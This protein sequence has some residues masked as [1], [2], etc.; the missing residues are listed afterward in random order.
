MRNKHFKVRHNTKLGSY[1]DNCDYLILRLIIDAKEPFVLKEITK[2]IKISES[3]RIDH[4]KKLLSIGLIKVKESAEDWR[5]REVTIT[6]KGKAVYE[7]FKEY[8]EDKLRE[9]LG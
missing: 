1:F 2:H 5:A 4:T 3:V 9:S 7:I 6:S 8:A